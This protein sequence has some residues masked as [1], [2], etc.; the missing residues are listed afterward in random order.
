MV[1]LFYLFVWIGISSIILSFLI[2]GEF[3]AIKFPKTKF[4][5]FWRENVIVEDNDHP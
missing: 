1:F 3:L 2:L 5:K 4:G